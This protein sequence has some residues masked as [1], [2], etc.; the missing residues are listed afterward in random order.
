V[1]RVA[2][3]PAGLVAAGGGQAAA[4][5]LRT[6]GLRSGLCATGRV[7]CWAERLDPSVLHL[8][9]PATPAGRVRVLCPRRGQ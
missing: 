1:G 2:L 6:T 5:P 3:H 9:E 8:F 4:V 7:P